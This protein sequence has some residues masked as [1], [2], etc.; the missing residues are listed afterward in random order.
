MKLLI[1]LCLTLVPAAALSASI[2]LFSTPD[3]S[4]CNLNIPSGGIGT[5]YVLAD[6]SDS[7]QGSGFGAEFR[8]TG[9]PP[10]WIVVTA[11]PNPGASVV[12]G[13]PFGQGVRMCCGITGSAAC[14]QL[15]TVVVAA[16][17]PAQE[18]VLRI[19]PAANPSFGLPCPQIFDDSAPVDPPAQ[20]ADRGVMFVNS[21]QECSVAVSPST[22]TQVKQHY[23]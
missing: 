9:L 21:N 16:P 14:I 15:Y 22:W 20:C 3:C 7:F 8:V 17:V 18:V 13:D 11:T 4:S 23:E 2:G 1:C 10:G 19:E 12:A 5:F 6:V